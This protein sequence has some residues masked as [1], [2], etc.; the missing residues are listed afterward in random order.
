[1]GRSIHLDVQGGEV[2][3]QVL[4]VVNVRLL[5]DGTHHVPDVL[6]PYCHREVLLETVVAHRTL[7][8]GERLHL[9]GTD[10]QRD[11]ESQQSVFFTGTVQ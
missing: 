9:E 8:G 5:A 6:V 3:V 7:T 2:T 11:G 10:R 4:G 1:M